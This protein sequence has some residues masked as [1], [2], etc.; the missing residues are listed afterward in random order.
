[1]KSNRTKK[2]RVNLSNMDKSQIWKIYD[3]DYKE[4]QI[5]EDESKVDESG[6]CHLCH[7]VL[8]IM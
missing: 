7:Y 1:M 4:S 8:F 5:I 3:Q 2:N 6:T